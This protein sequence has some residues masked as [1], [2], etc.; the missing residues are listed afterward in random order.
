MAKGIHIRFEG[1][2]ELQEKLINAKDPGAIKRVVRKNGAELQSKMQREAV[3]VKG[4]SKGETQQSISLQITDGGST[5]KVSPGT[6]YSPY[7]EYGT[8]FMEAQP[9]VVPAF[10]AQKDIFHKDI[11]KLVKKLLE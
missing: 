2:T 7:L 9:F 6:D 3:F 11:E 5:A 8:R 10:D 4:Y 1:L